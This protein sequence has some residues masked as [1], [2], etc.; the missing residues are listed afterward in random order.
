[1]CEKQKRIDELEL[2]L[3]ESH[4]REANLFKTLAEARKFQS[5]QANLNSQIVWRPLQ[6]ALIPILLGILAIVAAIIK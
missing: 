2:A 5:E 1:M 6:V 3:H 4:T